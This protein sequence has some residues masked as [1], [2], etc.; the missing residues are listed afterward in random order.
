MSMRITAVVLTLLLMMMTWAP[1]APNLLMD[2]GPEAHTSGISDLMLSFSNGPDEG[3][4]WTGLRSLSIVSAGNGTVTSIL[5]ERQA[6]ATGP[7][8]LVVNLTSTPYI[9][10]ISTTSIENGSHRFR[11]RAWDANVT[12]WSEAAITSNVTIANQAPVISGFSIL[13]ASVGTG[14]SVDDRAWLNV[15]SD[16]TLAFRWSATDD[17]L[18]GAT[19]ANVPGTGTPARD[20]APFD[21]GWDWSPGDLSEG[22]SAPRLTISDASGLSATRTMFLGIDRTPPSMSPPTIG[23]TGWSNSNAVTLNGLFPGATDG[24][25]SGV[26]RVERWNASSMIWES[27]GTA[28]SW[29]ST[30]PEGL[31]LERFRPVDRVGLI[32]EEVNV[33]VRVDLTDP[34]ASG[35]WDVPDLV[36]DRVGTVTVRIPASDAG[37]GI[38]QTSTQIEYGF[39]ANG[40]GTTPDLTGQWL[41]VTEPGSEGVIGVS[42]WVTKS[43]QYLMLRATLVDVAGNR[44][45]TEPTFHQILPSIDLSWNSTNVGTDRLIVTEGGMVVITSDIL[46]NEPHNGAITVLLQSAPADRRAGTEWSTVESRTLEIGSLTDRSEVLIWNYTLP[47]RGQVDL[48]LVLDPEQVLDER[49]EG[50]NEHYLVVTAVNPSS[51]NTGA[52]PSFVPGSL[53]VAIA[54]LLVA[55]CMGRGRHSSDHSMDS[56]SSSDITSETATGSSMST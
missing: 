2:E 41:S 44:I 40:V 18:D 24:S 42:N 4:S 50:N 37:S 48:R 35:A 6:N 11:A 7:W 55:L 30:Y 14:S 23:A 49:D 28:T 12:A 17:D 21:G 26:D 47:T 16:G 20:T 13:G 15:P 36:T 27:L 5:V 38:D 32:G 46:V 54:S 9:A 8:T 33:T 29:S 22:L 31:N 53:G 1:P 51:V 25:G 3:T 39:D 34:F 56:S 52:V 19:L 45:V 10:T 43:R